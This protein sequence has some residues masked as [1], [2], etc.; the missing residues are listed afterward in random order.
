[1]DGK[2]F[3]VVIA[4]GRQYL[5]TRNCKNDAGTSGRLSAEFSNTL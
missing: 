3:N 1:M 5:H 4:G 2:K